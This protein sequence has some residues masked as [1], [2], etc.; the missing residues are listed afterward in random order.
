MKYVVLPGDCTCVCLL[1][2]ACSEDQWEANVW[3][4][5]SRTV[6]PTGEVVRDKVPYALDRQLTTLCGVV[7]L[8]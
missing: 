3:N 2:V 4:I 1:Y 8:Y 7:R 5:L 6:S